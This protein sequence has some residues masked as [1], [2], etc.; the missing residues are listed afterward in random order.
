MGQIRIYTILKNL[1]GGVSREEP[2]RTYK[3]TS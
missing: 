1:Q 3:R 2:F